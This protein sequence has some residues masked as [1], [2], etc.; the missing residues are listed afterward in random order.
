MKN[1]IKIEQ[2]EKEEMLWF[3]GLIA[4]KHLEV[5]DNLVKCEIGLNRRITFD[6]VTRV[7][8]SFIETE[9]PTLEEALK[10]AN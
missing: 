2:S 1:C 9:A 5:T 4:P 3:D 8:A 6:G 7:V 10:V